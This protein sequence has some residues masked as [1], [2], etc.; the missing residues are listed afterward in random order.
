MEDYGIPTPGILILLVV[1]PRVGLAEPED[2]GAAAWICEHLV[3]INRHWGLQ[4][5][6]SKLSGIGELG[7]GELRWINGLIWSPGLL[8][9]EILDVPLGG[10]TFW[11]CV[12]GSTGRKTA[13]FEIPSIH[14]RVV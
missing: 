12:T 11:S 3:S 10:S 2:G 1:T 8:R 13:L 7:I 5:W 4:I 14:D 6:R 9:L